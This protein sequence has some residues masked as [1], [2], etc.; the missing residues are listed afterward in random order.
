MP[1]H[2]CWRFAT[3]G[4]MRTEL[5]ILKDQDDAFVDTLLEELGVNA[6]GL[7][8]KTRKES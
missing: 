8:K 4:L 1:S 7:A 2:G 6:D 3:N 5:A